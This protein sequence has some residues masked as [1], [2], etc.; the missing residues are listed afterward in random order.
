M[1]HVW[2]RR[3]THCPA[4]EAAIAIRHRLCEVC[5]RRQSATAVATWAVETPAHTWPTA[6]RRRG[7]AKCFAF[8]ARRSRPYY[9]PCFAYLTL[10]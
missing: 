9:Q 1:G 7:I 2:V 5:E 6:E 10:H 4:I 3:F 8:T